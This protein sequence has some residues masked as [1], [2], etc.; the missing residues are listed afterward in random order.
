MLRSS[1]AWPITLL[2]AI[3]CATGRAENSAPSSGPATRVVA[4][5]VSGSAK[6]RWAELYPTARLLVEETGKGTRL[7]VFRFD[8]SVAEVYDGD[9]ILDAADAGKLLKPLAEHQANTS[10]TNLAHVVRRIVQRARDWP[11]PIEVNIVTDCGTELMSESDRQFVKA[12][13][14]AWR[15]SGQVE[16]RFHGLTTGHRE[17]IRAIVPGCEIVER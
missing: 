1:S 6:E 14:E 8:V 16:M 12:T 9:G 2:L 7:A 3:G 5:D 17:E 4:V 15:A 10:G 11:E 13:A